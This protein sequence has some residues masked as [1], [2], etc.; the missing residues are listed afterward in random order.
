MVWN[1][2]I[3][4][5]FLLLAGLTAAILTA[6]FYID[7]LAEN[8]CYDTLEEVTKGLGAEILEHI[9]QEEKQLKIFA[10]M[11]AEEM[12]GDEIDFGVTKEILSVWP[13]QGVI[14]HLE[15]LLPDNRVLTGQGRYLEAEG[16]L[17]FPTQEAL[18]AHI[19][20]PEPD[21]TNRDKQILRMYV[22]VEKNGRAA[23]LLYGCI[24]L[25]NFAKEWNAKAFN[26]NA[27]IYLINGEDGQF[28]VDTWHDSLG[29]MSIL[30]GRKIKPGYSIERYR[31][32][33]RT[34]RSGHIVFVSK[35]VGE[36]FYLWYE[37]VGTNRWMVMVSVPESVAFSGARQIRTTFILLVFVQLVGFISYFLWA[38]SS[39]R[40]ETKDK[41]K[42]LDVV[43]YMYDVEKVLF[44]A[45]R[46]LEHIEEALQKVAGMASAK[47]AFFVLI[48]NGRREQS[49]IWRS[50]SDKREV[51]WSALEE[52]DLNLIIREFA[53]GADS[54]VNYHLEQWREQ[55]PLE[56][57]T[58]AD[59]EIRSLMI[60]PVL[61]I[62]QK[63]VGIL[64]AANMDRRYQTA[65]LL[66]SVTLSF[67]MLYHNIQMYHTIKEMGEM[68]F[69][70]GLLNRNCYQK[71]LLERQQKAY[72]SVGCVYVDANGLHELNNQYGHEA[73]DR[74]LQCIAKAMKEQFGGDYSYRIGG[75][76]FVAFC[77]DQPKEAVEQRLERLRRKVDQSGYCISIGMEYQKEPKDMEDII[78]MAER[79]MYDEKRRYYEE[80]GERSRHV[81]L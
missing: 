79:G 8:A 62:D 6:S 17:S 19:S 43:S 77:F 29:N 53:E 73:G 32:D 67:S 21:L 48:N 33:I 39:M 38:V 52:L 81:G 14:S 71:N 5:T 61:D 58:L 59:Y 47:L 40:Q 11:I 2:G 35:T 76:E 69:L 44:D 9:E 13:V 75:D 80:K 15:L 12:D 31:E 60:V 56:C 27:Q 34:N 66:E 51:D 23:A 41:Q 54:I 4:P 16:I 64:G 63:L 55:Y 25:S 45:H 37:P 10:N 49:Y 50:S 78:R 22:P 28:L 57:K 70:T 74:M 20:N 46:K 72:Q 36:Y 26:G 18:G 1:K 68:D 30:G 7:R 24:E 65:E 42:K 3:L